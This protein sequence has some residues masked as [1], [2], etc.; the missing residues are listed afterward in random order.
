MKAVLILASGVVA[1]ALTDKMTEDLYQF[2]VRF[3]QSI[4]CS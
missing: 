3:L 2:I 1:R 4:I